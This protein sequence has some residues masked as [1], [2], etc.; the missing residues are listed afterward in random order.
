MKPIYNSNLSF[1]TVTTLW[2]FKDVS[3]YNSALC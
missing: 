3:T 1:F 2:R